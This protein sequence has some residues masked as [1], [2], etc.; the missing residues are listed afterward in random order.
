MR[1]VRHESNRGKGAALRS[2]LRYA[3]RDVVIVQ[4]ADLE[5]DPRDYLQLVQPIL[6]DKADV[7]YGSRF[8][9]SRTRRGIRF[10]STLAHSILTPL[11]N[12]LT[13]L[14]LTDADTCYKTF[15]RDVIQRI[16]IEEDGFGFDHE[17]TAK[18]ARLPGVR[19][20]EV[21]IKYVGRTYREGKKIGWRDGLRMVWCIFKYNLRG[22]SFAAPWWI[23]VAPRAARRP[24]DET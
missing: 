18:V 17:I 1:V 11:S 24:P 20:C 21:G 19:V 5:Y 7:V 4:D 9:D 8:A 2:G 23:P 10:W 13:R 15:R 16:R 22:V 6:D 3:T 14:R 12:T